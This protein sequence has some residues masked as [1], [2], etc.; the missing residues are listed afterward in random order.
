LRDFFSGQRIDFGGFGV[1]GL[2]DGMTPGGSGTF[3]KS[4]HPNA[5][6]TL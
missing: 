5:C 1:G 3:P 6:Q 2:L 4:P